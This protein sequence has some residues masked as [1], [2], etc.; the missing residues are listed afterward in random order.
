MSEFICVCMCVEDNG[1]VQGGAGGLKMGGVFELV[2]WWAF[3]NILHYVRVLIKTFIEF[4][5]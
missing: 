2:G 1:F 4:K 5:Y 3:C